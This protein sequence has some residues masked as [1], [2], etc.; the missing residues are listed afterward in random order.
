MS[1]SSLFA[2]SNPNGNI[3]RQFSAIPNTAAAG[4]IPEGSSLINFYYFN[5][6]PVGVYNI[7][8]S[9]LLN[10]PN[11]TTQYNLL[12]SGIG[13]EPTTSQSSLFP[14]NYNVAL[15]ITN[16]LLAFPIFTSTFTINVTNANPIYINVYLLV[17]PSIYFDFNNNFNYCIA[18]KLA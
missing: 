9:F 4:I 17:S 18:T 2:F 15:P 7:Q 1:W 3:G 5:S 13:T 6:L 10:D 8:L 14:V 16:G 12:I 11:E